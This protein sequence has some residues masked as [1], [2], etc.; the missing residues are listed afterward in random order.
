MDKI[1]LNFNKRYS[2]ADD[3]KVKV[4]IFEDITINLNEV[5]KE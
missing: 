5:F 4:N 1:P 2:Y 3:S